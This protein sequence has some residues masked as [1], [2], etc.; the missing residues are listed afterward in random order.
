MNILNLIGAL[1][2]VGGMGCINYA[3]TAQ[4][5]TYEPHGNDKTSQ[6]ATALGWSIV[7]YA[8]Y[9]LL[10]SLLSVKFSGP[11][12]TVITMLLT[13]AASFVFTVL[14]AKPL[15]KFVYW[16]YNVVFKLNHEN[17][18]D[19][20]TIW[21]NFFESDKT[22]EV[23]CY[24]LQH[25]PIGQGFLNT[26]SKNRGEYDL[27]LQPFKEDQHKKQWSYDEIEEI[28]QNPENWDNYTIRQYVNT[29]ANLII[30][31]IRK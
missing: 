29:R 26:F 17:T 14:V 9:L 28:S 12:L 1:I 7:D 5:K 15:Q 6:V 10:N 25:N 11:Y 18:I 19:I 31:T 23:Y 22:T 16:C 21:S 3:V 30:F 27:T 24:D 8:L 2:T 20:G 13:M 4:L